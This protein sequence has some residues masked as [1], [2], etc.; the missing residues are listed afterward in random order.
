MNALS[1]VSKK[2]AE[3]ARLLQRDGLSGLMG[4]IAHWRRHRAAQPKIDAEY[5]TD[6][7]AWVTVRDLAAD[8]PNIPFASGYGPS[9]AYDSELILKQLPVHREGYAFVDLGCGKGLVLMLASQLGFRRIIGV[10]FA[11]NVYE[12]A[13]ANL[14]KFRRKADVQPIEVILGD[15][16]EFAFPPEPLVVYLYHPFGPEVILPVLENLRLSVSEHPRDCWVVYVNPVH[17]QVVSGCDFLITHK[18]VLGK[19]S[20]EPYALYRMKQVDPR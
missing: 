20:G 4:K 12:I 8:G 11:R 6:T 10:E 7:L 13:V 16:A 17:H 3:L 14:D 19:E 18:A 5:G 2:G 9:P 1:D 15:A